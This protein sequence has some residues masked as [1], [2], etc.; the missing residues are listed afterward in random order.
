VLGFVCFES[1]AARLRTT[2]ELECTP[3]TPDGSVGRGVGLGLVLDLFQVALFP[4]VLII[5]EIVLPPAEKPALVGLMIYF[6]LGALR[7][8]FT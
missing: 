5:C 4:S 7:G 6:V 3:P 1:L 8:F 2:F